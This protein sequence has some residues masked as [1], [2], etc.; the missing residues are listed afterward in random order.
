MLR[1][2]TASTLALAIAAPAFAASGTAQE[3]EIIMDE[4]W[5]FAITDFELL[6]SEPEGYKVV[7]AGT[8]TA[9]EVVGLRV[10]DANQ[11]WVGEIDNLVV[12]PTGDIVAAVVGVGGYLGIGEKDV[13][14][15]Y[16]SLMLTEN[17]EDGSLRIYADVTKEGLEELPAYEG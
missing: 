14:V 10:Y 7:D 9:N 4:K 3:G 8:M 13:V 2:L 6:K 1:V 11:E 5:D 15:N 17:M 16:D 12:T